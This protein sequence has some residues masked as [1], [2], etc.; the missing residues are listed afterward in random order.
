MDARKEPGPPISFGAPESVGR[1]PS[2]Q[3][4]KIGL[5]ERNRI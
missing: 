4:S 3:I 2:Y 1:E 5:V